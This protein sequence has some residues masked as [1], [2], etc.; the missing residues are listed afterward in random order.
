MTSEQELWEAVFVA[1][2]TGAASSECDWGKCTPDGTSSYT[3]YLCNR[4]ERLADA[5][6]ERVV[7]RRKAVA[8]MEIEAARKSRTP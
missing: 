1:S 8:R 3:A 2:L 4:A 6:V 5:A 7:S